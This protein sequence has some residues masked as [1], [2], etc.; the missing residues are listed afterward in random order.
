MVY[1]MSLLG[2]LVTAQDVRVDFVPIQG[3]ETM[4]KSLKVEGLFLGEKADNND[5]ND[6]TGRQAVP[7]DTYFLFK[8]T[9]WFSVFGGCKIF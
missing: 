7:F 2:W 4:T 3:H 5:F 6:R 1:K 9:S 8:E